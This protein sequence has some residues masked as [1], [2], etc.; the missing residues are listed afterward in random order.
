MTRG[1]W[2][3]PADSLVACLVQGGDHVQVERFAERA[4]FLGA[5]QHGDR[6]VVAGQGGNEILDGEGP[7]K[8][9]FDHARLFR[10]GD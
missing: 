10:P 8:P 1:S 6:P 9:D 4:R 5:I 2:R 3:E 7:V